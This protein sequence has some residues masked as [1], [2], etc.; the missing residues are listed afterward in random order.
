V[1]SSVFGTL[2]VELD[3]VLVQIR[4]FIAAEF[5]QELDYRA[6]LGKFERHNSWMVL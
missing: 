5:Q 2:V 1:A 3:I 6:G 4:I